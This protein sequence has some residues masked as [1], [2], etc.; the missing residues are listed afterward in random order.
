[1]HTWQFGNQLW[2]GKC[3]QVVKAVARTAAE[4]A[5]DVEHVVEAWDEEEHADHEEDPSVH[6]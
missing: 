5:D 3:G 2:S 4:R 6:V 1:M